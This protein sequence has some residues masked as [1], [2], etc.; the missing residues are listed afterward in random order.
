VDWTVIERA[1]G[2][3]PSSQDW[4]NLLHLV[5]K[6]AKAASTVLPNLR[7]R[8]GAHI[9][10]HGLWPRISVQVVGAAWSVVS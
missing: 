3:E 5:R 10:Q 8:V 7:A 1:D 6:Q 2:T 9:K 4:K